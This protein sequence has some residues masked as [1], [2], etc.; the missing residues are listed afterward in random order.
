[1]FLNNCELLNGDCLELMKNIPDKS[2]DMI[3]CDLPFGVT[4]NKK[5]ISLPF[6]LLWEQYKR[7]I[8]DKGCIALFAQGLFYVDLV[9]SNRKWFRY[10]IIWDKVLT[11]GFLNANRMPLRS[12]EQIAIFY[13]KLPKYYPIFTEGEPLHSKGKTYKNKD[14]KNQNYGDFN[15]V[16]DERCGS[17]EKYPKSIWIF[18]KPHPSVAKHATEKSIPLLEELIKTYTDEND[19]ILDNTMGSG[20]CAIASINTNRK[21][22]GMELDVDIYNKTINRIKECLKY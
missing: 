7:I 20:T 6:N 16:D 19:T 8:K 1:M 2:I 10:D 4:K 22:I 11:S 17:T 18:S 21:F 5:D 13:K 3:L 15:M 14:H 12:H 9:N